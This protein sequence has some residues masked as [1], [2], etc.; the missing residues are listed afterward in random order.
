MPYYIVTGVVQCG[1]IDLSKKAQSVNATCE[2]WARDEE[3][4]TQKATNAAKGA[5][6]ADRIEWTDGPHVREMTQEEQMRLHGCPTL[7]GMEE[8]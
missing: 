6:E 2:V 1:Y 5:H 3:E 8:I 7:P 4:A